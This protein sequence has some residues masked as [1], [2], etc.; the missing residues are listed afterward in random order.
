MHPPTDPLDPLLERWRAVAPPLERSV[1]DEVWRRIRAARAGEARPGWR[2]RIEAV[3]AQ[4]AFVV[5]FVTA[6]MLLGQFLAEVRVSRLQADRDEQLARSYVR[7]ID[8][9]LENARLPERAEG[10]RP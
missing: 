10:P 2:A 5:A 4:P 3:F 7:L 9:L 1:G 8:P 6:C